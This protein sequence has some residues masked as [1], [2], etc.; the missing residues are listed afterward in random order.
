MSSVFCLDVSHVV[1]KDRAAS[2]YPSDSAVATGAGLQNRLLP[3]PQDAATRPQRPLLGPQVSQG[4]TC[5]Q[6]L[7]KSSRKLLQKEAGV[8]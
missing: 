2:E 1:R 3:L 8:I 4:L 7:D 5:S 6:H